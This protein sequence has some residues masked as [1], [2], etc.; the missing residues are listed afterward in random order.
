MK[1]ILIV[2][3]VLTLASCASVPGADPVKGGG[4]VPHDMAAMGNRDAMC[5]EHMKMM[6]DM[7]QKMSTKT[8]GE[9]MT[10]MKEHMKMMPGG[11]GMLEAGKSSM[12]SGMEM[13][14]SM[15]TCRMDMMEMKMQMMMQ[16]MVDRDAAM[17]PPA[18]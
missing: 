17:A 11:M 5:A 6:K 15:A 1:S 3:A 12:G 9:R 13:S 18:K 4:A 14:G 7:Q 8:P 2:A 10:M 16:M